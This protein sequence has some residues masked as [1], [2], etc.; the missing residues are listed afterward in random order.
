V[1]QFI[2]LLV[3]AYLAYR[4]LG[5]PAALAVVVA[6]FAIGYFYR[7]WRANVD[8]QA[9]VQVLRTPLSDAEKIHMDLMKERDQR[10]SERQA[11]KNKY[12]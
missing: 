8:R 12:R 1:L 3:A 9:A 5:W 10:M 11:T 4:W 6:Y 7:M 2:A